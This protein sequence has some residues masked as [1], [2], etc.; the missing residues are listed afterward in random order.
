MTATPEQ[1][2]AHVGLFRAVDRLLAD[3]DE[4]RRARAEL[5]RLLDPE[6]V[7]NGNER[8]TTADAPRG[9]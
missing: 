7:S 1:I 3:A 6:Q 8:K 9:R 2:I 4:V 5:A